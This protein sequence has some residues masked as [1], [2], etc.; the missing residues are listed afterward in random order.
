MMN[1]GIY[2]IRHKASGRSYIG[3]SVDIANRWSLHKRH[4]EQGRDRSPLHR[5]LRKYGYDAFVWEVLV[6]APARVQVALEQQFIKDQDTLAPN[7]YNVGGAAGGYPSRELLAA[8]DPD[9]RERYMAEMRA[10]SRKMHSRLMELRKDPEYEAYYRA[11]KSEAAKK[12]WAARK[13]RM[14]ADPVFAA[15]ANAKWLARARKAADT[16]R[17]RQ[18]E[19]PQFARRMFDTRSKAAKIARAKDRGDG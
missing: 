10:T 19:D 2:R 1:S 17:R 11:G 12:R 15:E 3:R 8:M 5:A 6:K 4:T 9:T 13:A 18:N 7:G 16:I 14:A